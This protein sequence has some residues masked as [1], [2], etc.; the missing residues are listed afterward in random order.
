MHLEYAIRDGGVQHGH[1]DGQTVQLALQFGKNRG[2]RRR[3]A[4]GGRRQV[5]HTRAAAPKVLGEG[6]KQHQQR[7]GYCGLHFRAM[8]TGSCV[9]L[10]NRLQQAVPPTHHVCRRLFVVPTRK[11]SWSCLFL[12]STKLRGVRCHPILYKHGGTAIVCRTLLS[13]TNAAICRP[14]LLFFHPTTLEGTSWL[15]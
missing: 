11:P 2:D 10:Q 6:G 9:V 1:T 14:A 13:P 5:K 12:T 7:E 3:R 8:L 4:C 15:K